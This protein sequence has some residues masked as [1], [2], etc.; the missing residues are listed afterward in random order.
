LDGPEA[1]G[2]EIARLSAHI[3]AATHHLL[4]LIRAFDEQEGWAWGF[5]SCAEW[6]SWRTG[7]SPGPAR[8]KVRV[9]R[10]LGDLHIL[11][12]A[13]ARGELSFSKV[14]ALT[15][16]ATAEN[17]AELL[18]LARQAT[19]AQLERIV[20][21]WR[22]VD[23]LEDAE[24]AEA[25][26]ARRHANRFLRLHPDQD[27]SWRIRGRLDPEVGALL[28]KALEWA[29][30]ALYQRKAASTPGDAPVSTT[31]VTAVATAGAISGDAR[32]Q[33][34]HEQRCA[35]ALGLLAER[36]LAGDGANGEKGEGYGE[37]NSPEPISR[38][39]RFQVVVHVGGPEAAARKRTTDGAGD[40]S[41][42]TSAR[43]FHRSTS[44]DRGPRK[45]VSA[46]T[47]T[48]C[49]ILGPN[50][51]EMPGDAAPSSTPLSPGVF[52]AHAPTCLPPDTSTRIACDADLV[53]M[54]HDSGGRVLD[55][56]RKRRTVPPA[57]RRALD[58]RDGGCRFPGC[59][60]RYADAHHVVH[61]A[62]GGETKLGNLVLLCR[63][64]HRAVHEEGFRVKVREG[65]EGLQFRFY[66]PD[67]EPFPP[68]PRTP[69]VPA[70]AMADLVRRNRFRGVD[71]D[72]GTTT[73]SWK[74]E[75]LD[76]GMA[77][78]MMRGLGGGSR[79]RVSR[80]ES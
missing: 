25:A 80:M 5:R 1:L 45:Q 65:P 77:I 42:E 76:L 16:V 35:D 73:S 23:R 47:P 60:C 40:V 24:R 63:R 4:V 64:H 22:L 72:A 2:E 71:P 14:R 62:D 69:T 30:E 68:V 9:A 39:E 67:G 13:M 51:G 33:A 34:T 41:A 56:G 7:I 38:A 54:I 6:L 49:A 28:E 11:S 50:P 75:K 31:S 57:I 37:R 58:Y 10:A 26:E 52:L 61:W 27:G 43:P 15:R 59:N 44:M 36:A 18:K 53:E 55:V 74:G 46:E 21:G 79:G 29:R 3:H 78:D 48:D 70:D 8:E 66:R 12:R 32:D 20:R 17:E 19:A